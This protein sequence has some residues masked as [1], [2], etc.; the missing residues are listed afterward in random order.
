[1]AGHWIRWEKG[2][3]RKSEVLRIA[4]TLHSAPEHAAGLCMRVWEWADDVTVDGSVIDMDAED[5]DMA[6]GYK[7][8][9]GAMMAVNWIHIEDS[10]LKFP[11]WE[12][13]NGEPA[14]KRAL[15]AHRMRVVRAEHR[16]QE[17]DKRAKCVR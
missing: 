9:G 6:A 17:L 4:R 2:L 16:S 7:G 3:A 10:C 15:N 14:K 13:F 11:N 12:R 5:I 8:I 1:M